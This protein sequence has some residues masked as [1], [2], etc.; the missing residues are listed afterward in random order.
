MDD[1]H[2]GSPRAVWQKIMKLTATDESIEKMV[3]DTE[4]N[5]GEV[6]RFEAEEENN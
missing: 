5:G 2:D 4:A 6:H 1:G 3:K